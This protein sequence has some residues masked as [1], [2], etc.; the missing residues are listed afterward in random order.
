MHATVRKSLIIEIPIFIPCDCTLWLVLYYFHAVVTLL[1]NHRSNKYLIYVNE[2][3]T[4]K[5][6]RSYLSYYLTSF[7]LITFYT[8]QSF[9]SQW[10]IFVLEF[11]YIKLPVCKKMPTLKLYRWYCIIKSK[12]VGAKSNF[13]SFYIFY[14]KVVLLFRQI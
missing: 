8:C 3:A 2:L 5:I 12:Y 10:I 13:Y 11:M 7:Y 9:T 4:T 6:H 14:M 1:G